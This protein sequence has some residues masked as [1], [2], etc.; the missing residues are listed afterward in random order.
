[1]AKRADIGGMQVWQQL[2]DSTEDR[3][4]QTFREAKLIDIDRIKPNPNQV[5]QTF[6]PE[7][8]KEL[9]DSIR[10]HG[11]IQPILVR[12][13]G[14]DFLIIAGERRHRASQMAGLRQMPCIVTE[15]D[16]LQVLEKS[17]IEN[18]QREDINPVEEAQ[19]YQMLQEEYGYTIRELAGK[20]KKSVGYIH[21]RFGLLEHSDLAKR[22]SQ[23]E[24]GV[25]EARELGKIKDEAERQALTEQVASGQL[26]RQAL[27]REVEARTSEHLPPTFDGDTFSR[28]WDRLR[29]DLE[30]EIGVEALAGAEIE[31]VRQ[32]LEEMKQTI[33][34]MLEQM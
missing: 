31:Q 28:R 10:A 8:L 9:A 7:P 14:D 17:L 1:V 5:R 21:S 26:D 33:E 18:I 11:L 15:A 13:E 3:G 6:E 19:C 29:R 27:K 25:F 12:P 2:A 30:K 4:V 34:R 20:V 22:V 24:I 32:L 16:D 23:A